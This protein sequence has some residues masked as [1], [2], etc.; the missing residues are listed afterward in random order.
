MN[1]EDKERRVAVGQKVAAEKAVAE[2]VVVAVVGA[3]TGAATRRCP[4]P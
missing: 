4:T 1:L 2:K 3:G